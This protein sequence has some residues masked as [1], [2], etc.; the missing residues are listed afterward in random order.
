MMSKEYLVENI[1]IIDIAKQSFFIE[2]IFDVL[3][4]HN[5]LSH[6]LVSTGTRNTLLTKL[7]GSRY[8]N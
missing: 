1:C 4:N 7:F 2:N 6:E 3:G 8:K 5:N